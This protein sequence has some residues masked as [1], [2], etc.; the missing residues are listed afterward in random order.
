MS[1]SLKERFKDLEYGRVGTFG[2]DVSTPRT[3]RQ[4]IWH[5]QLFDHAFL[6]GLWTN[7][8]Q[9]AP[10]VWRS[11]QPSPRRIHR[12]KQLG[13]NTILSLRGDHPIS[14]NLLEKQVCEW[15]VPTILG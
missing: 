7:L 8:A 9:I 5:F 12:Y 6:R 11:N 2:N 4:A 10:G 15:R 13:I 14:Y 3:Y 1:K